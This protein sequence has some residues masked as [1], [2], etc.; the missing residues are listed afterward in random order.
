[1][2]LGP[3]RSARLHGRDGLG[4]A[5]VGAEAGG[6]RRRSRRAQRPS[7]RVVEAAMHA[8]TVNALLGG[9]RCL[10]GGWLGATPA[11]ARSKLM[12][13]PTLLQL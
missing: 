6:A 1:M 3:G 12:G 9:G 7:L 4:A 8:G 13:S 2:R 5:G 10:L 11:C